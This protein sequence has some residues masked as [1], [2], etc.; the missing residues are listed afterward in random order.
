MN[1]LPLFLSAFALS[2]RLVITHWTG[3]RDK[4]QLLRIFVRRSA[5]QQSRTLE[6]DSEV[7]VTPHFETL[8]RDHM[9]GESWIW[10]RVFEGL[11][12]VQAAHGREL[13]RDTLQT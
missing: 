9:K 3:A 8:A 1:I 12:N 13:F 5:F 4:Q 11:E 6:R 2:A 7:V 10:L